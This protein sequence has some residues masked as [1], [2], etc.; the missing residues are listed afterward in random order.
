MRG[1]KHIQNMAKNAIAE[2]DEMGFSSG[3][4]EKQGGEYRPHPDSTTSV[5]IGNNTHKGPVKV[6]HEN[7][8]G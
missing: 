8:Y 2:D 3:E 7:E 4:E 6:V 5:R 1:M